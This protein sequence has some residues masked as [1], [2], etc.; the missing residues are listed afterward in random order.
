M[1]NIAYRGCFSKDQLRQIFKM[2]QT[3]F[4][5]WLRAIEPEVL[6]IDPTYNKH[7]SLLSPKVFRFL[8]AE[9]G[10]E[11]PAE[12]NKR[13]EDYYNSSGIKRNLLP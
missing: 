12:M 3:S 6:K 4:K 11:D 9:Y 13:I 8:M 2:R 5:K 10:F 1:N 7:C